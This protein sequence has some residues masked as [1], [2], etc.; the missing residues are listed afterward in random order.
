MHKKIGLVVLFWIFLFG[1]FSFSYAAEEAA[2]G[3]EMIHWQTWSLAIF[4]RAKEE[5]K[6][7]LIFGKVGWCHWCQKTESST[8][9]DPRVI[10]LINKD[11]VPVKVDIEAD[12]ALARRYKITEFP[13]FIVLDEH[14]K[15]LKRFSGYNSPQ[16]LLRKLSGLAFY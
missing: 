6:L 5:H 1:F 16:G 12:A 4:E 9:S 14:N 3:P 7:I 11:Y 2:A 10:Q 13:V 8:F 15:E